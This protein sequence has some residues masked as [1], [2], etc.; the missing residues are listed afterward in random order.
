VLRGLVKTWFVGEQTAA[1]QE[2]RD[3]CSKL[4]MGYA[5]PE[6]FA[7]HATPPG[8]Y[9]VVADGRTQTLQLPWWHHPKVAAPQKVY[10]SRPAVV[11]AAS[12]V[13]TERLRTNAGGNAGEW[14]EEE[15]SGEVLSESEALLH[16]LKHQPQRI[17]PIPTP[18]WVS[19]KR[20]R[21]EQRDRQ[22]LSEIWAAHVFPY[23]VDGCYET[24]YSPNVEGANGRPRCGY[25]SQPWL[26]YALVLAVHDGLDLDIVKEEMK[27]KKRSANHKC[28]NNRCVRIEHLEWKESWGA[29]AAEYHERRRE[30]LRLLT[31]EGVGS[32]AAL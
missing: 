23:G 14:E 7:E 32:S 1:D 21:P 4:T 5:P 26:V 27:A 15:E 16:L 25:M 19:G 11:V 12:S 30:T 18:E 22:R 8:F 28:E 17:G 3:W 9:Y 31:A 2:S 6:N 13:P 10:S 29:N 20:L 24:T